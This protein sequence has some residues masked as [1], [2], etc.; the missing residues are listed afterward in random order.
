MLHDVLNDGRRFTS[1]SATA[2]AGIPY[3]SSTPVARASYG[4]YRDRTPA[5]TA[6]LNGFSSIVSKLMVTDGIDREDLFEKYDYKLFSYNDRLALFTLS[7]VPSVV[8]LAVIFVGFRGVQ[9]IR[10]ALSL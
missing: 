3:G 4:P 5:A 1:V 9:G 8:V 10:R 6:V 7:T 2:A